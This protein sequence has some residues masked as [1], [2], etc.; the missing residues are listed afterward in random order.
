M[1]AHERSLRFRSLIMKALA[2]V[3]ATTLSLSNE[4]FSQD[5]ISN[6]AT[7]NKNFFNSFTDDIKNSPVFVNGKLMIF[8]TGVKIE[9][10]SDLI[11]MDA[12]DS[13]SILKGTSA[14]AAFG[15]YFKNGAIAITLKKDANP[16]LI[17]Y[18]LADTLP[19]FTSKEGNLEEWLDY[20]IQN[21]QYKIKDNK[22]G[23]VIVSFVIGKK[24]KV[25]DIKIQ[26]SP[27]TE[28]SA[29]ATSIISHMPDWTPGIYKGKTINTSYVLFL[30]FHLKWVKAT[31][32]PTGYMDSL[33]KAG[34]QITSE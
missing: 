23:V 24:G 32:A 31:E 28:F 11:D 27:S 9:N 16:K 25:S 8:A 7:N 34:H 18:D 6:V 13:I 22:T 10:F 14:T 29:E 3:T 33:R 30:Y 17:P 4:A 5:K 26:H 12:I 20:N 19:A 1:N 2:F 21:P 15:K